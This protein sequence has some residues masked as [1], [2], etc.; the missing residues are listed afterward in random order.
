MSLQHYCAVAKIRMAN[1]LDK[2][3]LLYM[4]DN[5]FG[6]NGIFEFKNNSNNEFCDFCGCTIE[7]IAFRIRQLSDSGLIRLITE[8]DEI[9]RKTIGE[10]VLFAVQLL[11]GNEYNE[12]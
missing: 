7:E 3:I 9:R 4:A 5:C 8:Q 11:H 2:L 10:N 12:A 1:P 6:H